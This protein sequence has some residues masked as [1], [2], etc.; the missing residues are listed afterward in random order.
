MKSSVLLPRAK[1]Q[2]VSGNPG[3]V[4]GAGRSPSIPSV[5]RGTDAI[6]G[7]EWACLERGAVS[8]P[9]GC[10]SVAQDRWPV[11]PFRRRTCV[12]CAGSRM[13][14]PGARVLRLPLREVPSTK[15]AHLAGLQETAPAS[16]RVRLAGLR[17][18]TC[19]EGLR[20]ARRVAV[21][22][23]GLS[24]ACSEG[25]TCGVLRERG[26]VTCRSEISHLTRFP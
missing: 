15:E 12:G 18:G 5:H 16:P 23:P 25:F 2:M 13:T 22:S 21:V 24:G 11:D 17:P 1:A 6:A 8:H 26:H 10:A 14:A 19:S 4:H 9:A 3:Y 7:S 20:W